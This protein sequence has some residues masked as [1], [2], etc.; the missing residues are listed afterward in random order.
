MEVQENKKVFLLCR[1][2]VIYMK[3]ES[4]LILLQKN[5]SGKT[6][7]DLIDLCFDICDQFHLVLRKD[8]GSLKSFDKFLNKIDSALVTMK[9]ESEWAS[10]ILDE[11]QTAKVYYYH[12]KDENV[13]RIIKET[14]NSLYEWEMPNHPEDLSF[15]KDGE[16]WLATSSHE[17]ECYIFPKGEEVGRIMNINGIDATIEEDE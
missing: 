7:N 13:K 15:F 1:V 5:P 9:E 17:R 10:T 4:R 12:T 16:V 11:G 14:V 3:G 2:L 8:M 6:Y